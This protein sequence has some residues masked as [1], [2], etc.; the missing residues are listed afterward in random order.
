VATQIK[1]FRFTAPAATLNG[2]GAQA[3]T[4]VNAWLTAEL[5]AGATVQTETV[6]A[7]THGPEIEGAQ[8]A[9]NLI[10]T[11]TITTP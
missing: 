7:Q 9:Y 10:L 4:T 5:P 8:L 11:L 1:V 2:L 3:E 6:F